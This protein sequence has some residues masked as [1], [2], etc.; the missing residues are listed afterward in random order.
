[1]SIIQAHGSTGNN[2]GPVRYTVNNKNWVI[3]L[4]LLF[5]W[6]VNDD[7]HLVVSYKLNL[8]HLQLI[9]HN[10]VLFEPITCGWRPQCFLV[11]PGAKSRFCSASACINISVYWN[12]CITRT[13]KKPW[14]SSNSYA[15]RRQQSAP[16]HSALSTVVRTLIERVQFVLLY[17]FLKILLRDFNLHKRDFHFRTP[18]CDNYG[19]FSFV[20]AKI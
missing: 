20:V 19:T 8:A 13:F 1:M 5:K 10:N 9:S 11:P 14:I 15:A 7:N 16:L 17:Q 18:K 4:S 3:L 12:T 6:S 2:E